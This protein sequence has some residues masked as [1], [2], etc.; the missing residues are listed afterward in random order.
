MYLKMDGFGWMLLVEKG[1][2]FCKGETFKTSTP[3]ASPRNICRTFDHH[4]ILKV[5]RTGISRFKI[6]RCA[7]LVSQTGCTFC[8][9]RLRFF[10]NIAGAMHLDKFSP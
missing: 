4:R 6:L 8:V 1:F 10:T 2:T 9:V 5:Q 7:C 3:A